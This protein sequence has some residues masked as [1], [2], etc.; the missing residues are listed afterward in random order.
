MKYI[1]RDKSVITDENLEHLYTFKQFPAFISYENDRDEK[2]DIRADMSISIGSRSGII[3]LDKVHPLEIVYK[4]KHSAGIGNIWMQHYIKFS[5]FIDSYNPRKIL[6]IGGGNGILATLYTSRNKQSSWTIVEP[7]PLL[8]KTKKIRTIN[9]WFDKNFVYNEKHDVIIHS[10]VLEHI[11]FPKEFLDQIYNISSIGEKHIFSVPNLKEW[12]QSKYTNS[13]NF[14][15]TI[16]LFE[17]FIDYLLSVTGFKIIE[18]NYYLNHSIFYA[19]EKVN[20]GSKTVL[21]SS[22]DES[23]IIFKEFINFHKNLIRDINKTISSLDCDVYLYG[24][25]IFSQFLL[26]FGIE[27]KKI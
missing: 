25:H 26:E 14:E 8:K 17:D 9:K 20:H 13:I 19:T 23:R 16:L 10:H 3:Q 15:H 1:P 27:K 5:K 21:K 6:E 12:I 7:L 2:K 11:Y 4:H 18:K 22:Y 24:A